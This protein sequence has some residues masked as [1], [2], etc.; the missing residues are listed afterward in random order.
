M[1]CP[2]CKERMGAKKRNGVS[3]H[4][5]LYCDGAWL[6]REA[7]ESLHNA[8]VKLNP[9]QV[10]KLP[11]ASKNETISI[12][13]PGCKEVN[14]RVIRLHE[15]ELDVCEQCS[16]MFFDTGE[17]ESLAKNQEIKSNPGITEYMTMEGL[18]WLVIVFLS[19]G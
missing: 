13:C 8:P 3:Y 10:S 17:L 1:D 9:Q 12:Q 6:S 5:C 18:F 14:L 15:I 7:L 4:S 11:L 19:G 16:G 2:K